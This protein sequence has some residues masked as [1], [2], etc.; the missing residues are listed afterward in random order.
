MNTR[1][2]S[3]IT[4]LI[5]SFIGSVLGSF[6]TLFV[7]NSTNKTLPAQP[8]NT[9]VIEDEGKSQNVY[10]AVT[11]KAMPSVV[12]ITT[13]TI[14]TNNIFAI[15]QQAQGVGT[16]FIVDSKGYI[17]TNSHVV[18]DGEAIEVN[19]LFNDGTTEKGK[20][21]WSDYQLDLAI[22]KVNKKNLTPCALGDSDEVRVGDISVAIGNPL[23]LEFQKSVTQGIISGLDR[24]IQTE[25]TLMTG[26][27]QT[28]ASINPGNSGGPLLNSEGEV[29]A[30]NTAKAS[31]AE[32]LG[33]A[34]PINI[35]KPI[36]EQIIK[37]G[38]FEKLTL[39]VKIVDVKMF[40]TIANV[41]LDADEGIY[42]LEVL[43][44]SPAG[45]SDVD[46]GDVITQIGSIPIKTT[47][48]L[49]KALYGY[50]KGDATKIKINRSGKILDVD[51]TF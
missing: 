8:N 41:N 47:S 13:V 29:I 5:T 14:D 17:L 51:V 10:H 23:G 18:S 27:M 39:G 38:T 45:R 1:K 50:K 46:P 7:M 42:V 16:G 6:I 22:V 26:L 15:P 37:T 30:I 31:M 35:T 12:G 11:T 3:I 49:N 9:I 36:I 20:V 44:N 33:F 34:I 25:K 19:V 2:T 32:G 40:E 48:D 43:S 21:L 24:N 28:D 4:I